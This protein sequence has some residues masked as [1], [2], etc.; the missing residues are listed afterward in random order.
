VPL[1]LAPFEFTASQALPQ[2]AQ[3][4]VVVIAVSQPFT[5]G[6]VRLQSAKPAL[7]LA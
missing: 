5:S 6:A 4:A 1:Q 3:L 2:P 7:Q